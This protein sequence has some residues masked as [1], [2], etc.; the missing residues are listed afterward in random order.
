[1]RHHKLISVLVLAAAGCSVSND[2]AG[3]ID[4]VTDVPDR[5]TNE[6]VDPV[7][8]TRDGGG[9]GILI[10]D[11][12]SSMNTIRDATGNTRCYDA[13]I[14]AH[15]IINT[16]FD[17]DG[18]DGDGIAIWA[19]ANNG[20][21]TDDVQPT[22]TGYYSDAASAI[23]AVN[24][25]TCLGTTPLADALC[26]GLNGDGE[27]FTINPM[28]DEMFILTDGY[29]DASNGVCSGP[30]GSL[31]T[32]GTWQ[33]NVLLEMF[34][35]GIRVDVRYWVNPT[36]LLQPETV[37]SFTFGEEE[38]YD[39]FAE[40]LEIVAD[41]EGVPLGQFDQLQG[42]P[43]AAAGGHHEGMG[44]CGVAC[45]ELALFEEM[46]VE[47][48]GSWGVVADDDNRYP[49]EGRIDPEEGPVHPPSKPAPPQLEGE[50]A[51]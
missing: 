38:P 17:P 36:I 34:A 11:T 35:T 1:M 47:S 28:L 5:P 6:L 46:A 12:T 15:G 51:F 13:Q 49:S 26:K 50:V 23:A 42:E 16:F 41:V 30:S 3:A 40:E 37:D 10:F 19:F 22:S 48:G 2:D 27:T 20:S 45:R 24:S 7:D 25:L 32:P 39:P 31:F 4:G 14:M 44:I 33:N 18:K 29:E 8:P 9:Y 21:N 43:G